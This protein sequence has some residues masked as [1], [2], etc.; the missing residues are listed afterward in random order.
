MLIQTAV[1][2]PTLASGRVEHHLK[3]LVGAQPIWRV[4][5]GCSKTLGEGCVERTKLDLFGVS[6]KSKLFPISRPGMAVNRTNTK[7]GKTTICYWADT[8]TFEFKS[9]LWTVVI[10]L[11]GLFQLIAL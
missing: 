1:S 3:N 6:R 7:A 11:L 5:E 2:L 9:Y 4:Q 8:E 10:S